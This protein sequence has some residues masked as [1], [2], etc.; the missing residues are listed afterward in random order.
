M[1]LNEFAIKQSVTVLTFLA[2]VLVVGTYSYFSLPREASPEVV[3]PIVSVFVTYQGVAPEDMESLVTI[4]IERKLTG[5]SDVKEISSYS[6]EGVSNTI[7]EFESGTDIESSIQKVRDKVDMAR[8]DLPQEADEPVINEI[9]ISELPV[10]ILTLHGDLSLAAL[11]F[12]AEDLEDSIEAIKGVLSADIV[13]GVEREIV[14]EVDPQRVAQYG[15]SMAELAQIARLENVNTPSGALDMGEAKYLVRVPG[16]FKT[17]DELEGL[18]VKQSP[19][20]VVYLRDI[21]KVEDTFKEPESLARVNGK[22]AVILAI[23]KRAGENIIGVSEQVHKVIETARLRLPKGVEI[24]VSVDMSDFV[25]DMVSELENGILSGLLLVLAAIFLFMG[26]R[27]A[28]FIAVAIPISMLLTFAMLYM[29]DVTL[30]MIVLFSLILVLGNLVDCSI[31][32]VEN[33]YRHMQMGKNRVDAALVGASEVA[34]PIIGSTLTTVA[35]FFPLLFWPGII[36]DFMYYLPCTVCTALLAS[37]FVGMVVNPAIA[38]LW[39]PTPKRRQV[40]LHDGKVKRNR[41]LLG[42]GWLL[43][44]ALRWRF[45][46]AIF[47]VTVLISIVAIFAAGAQVEFMPDIEP[48][49]ANID[50]ECPEGTNLDT[51]DSMVRLVESRI[52]PEAANMDYIIS[53]IGSGGVSHSVGSGANANHKSR[54]TLDFPELDECKILPSLVIANVRKL[55]G[56]VSGA[57]VRIKKE[58]DG[59]PTGPPVNIEL[60]GEDFD[61]LSRLAMDIKRR[62]RDVRGLVDLRDDYDVGKPEVRVTVDRQRASLAG[63]NTQFV[64]LT[65]RAAIDGIKAGE[66]REGDEEY[67]VTVRFPRSFREDFSNI[68][69]MNLINLAGA[70]IPFS[71]VANIEQGGGLGSIRRIDRKRT[72]TVMG[73]VEGRPGPEVLQ[74]IRQMLADYPLPAGYAIE[75]TGENEDMEET[76][77]FLSRA[78]IAA[79]F[80]ITLV[81]VAEFNSIIQPLIIMSTVIL[82]LSGVFM[83]LVLFNMPFD[84][85]MTGLA[86]VGLAGVVVNNGIVLLDFINQQRALGIPTEEAIVEAGLTRFRP[87]M[88]TAV[89]TVIGLVPMAIGLS[90]DFREFRWIISGES[91]QW[92]GPLAT[93]F[94]VGLLFATFLTLLVV[95]VLYSAVESFRGLFR[96]ERKV[97][98]SELAKVVAVK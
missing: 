15:V 95:P 69:A 38:S 28:L 22:P 8:V 61:V 21:A 84:I 96:A 2:L 32:V 13:G 48:R 45:V 10:I 85:V 18:I 91:A 90:F 17:P 86:V 9:N 58:E 73:D 46:T 30:N 1:K 20:G 87:V 72:V 49:Q 76:Q 16:E 31:V 34:W 43:R 89:T 60:T 11:N 37:L 70:P 51:S 24:G 23:S 63:L 55:I 6:L 44:K 77:A 26:L 83:S 40:I 64:G 80:L 7:I 3:I 59:P 29:F 75:Y 93:A 92:W 62:I 66:Y 52:A 82:S 54:I 97:E 81:M 78:F 47:F 35:G 65:V 19:E 42:Y 14:I 56:E 71:A 57:E 36:G 41:L 33:T 25:R 53:N 98:E 94:I 79:L 67:D 5:I 74:E 4:P 39:M 12:I 68:Q 50:V 88:L 27:N